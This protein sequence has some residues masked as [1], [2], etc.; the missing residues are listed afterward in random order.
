VAQVVFVGA[1]VATT[2]VVYRRLNRA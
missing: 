1:V 2:A